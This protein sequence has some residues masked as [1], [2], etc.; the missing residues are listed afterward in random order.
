M[1]VTQLRL[2]SGTHIRGYENA[3]TKLSQKK[4]KNA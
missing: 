4:N 1:P 3:I 2:S